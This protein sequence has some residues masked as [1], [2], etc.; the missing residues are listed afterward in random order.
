M[1]RRWRGQ[2]RDVVDR[3]GPRHS[4]QRV[5]AEAAQ[6]WSTPAAHAWR[7][8]SHW[9]DGIPGQWERVGDDHLALFGKLARVLDRAPSM[10]TVVEWGSGGGANAVAFAP[11][12]DRFVAVD[13][14][15]ASLEECERRTRAVCDTPFQPVLI[16]VEHPEQAVEHIGR[17]TCD[18]FLCLYVI[19][20]LPS[21]DYAR[22]VLD[23][24]RELLGPSGVMFVQIKYRDNADRSPHKRNYARNLASQTIFPIDT[25]WQIATAHGF[26][27]EVVSLVPRNDLDRNYA[28]LLLTR[29][30]NGEDIARST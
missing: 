15:R 16:E 28:Y 11:G 12:A 27:P 20:L 13:V 8:N 7:G 29:S 22:R 1:V 19:E 21:R 9:R 2:V 23:I 10:G 3:V 4:E 30:P 18:V 5:I 17:G 26:T 6:Y 25:F 24:A 14:A